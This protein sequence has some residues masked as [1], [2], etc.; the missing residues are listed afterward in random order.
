VLQD[1]GAETVDDL[2]TARSGETP[3]SHK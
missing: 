1:G 3:A 2:A